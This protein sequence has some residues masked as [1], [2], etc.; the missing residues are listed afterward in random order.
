MT[1]SGNPRPLILSPTPYIYPLRPLAIHIKVPCIFAG[2]SLELYIE[3]DEYIAGLSDGAGIRVVLHNNTY[4]PF[5]E[6]NGV[7]IMPGTKTSIGIRKVRGP[8]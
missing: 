3:Q 2:L 7:S 4:M 1:N 6:D 8:I 5:P